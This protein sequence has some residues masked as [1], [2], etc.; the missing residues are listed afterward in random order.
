VTKTERQARI[1]IHKHEAG[2]RLDAWL[3]GRFTYHALD[4]WVTLIQTERLLVNDLPSEADY[5]LCT[6]DVIAYHP[7]SLAEPEVSR[8]IRVLFED[9]F[10]LAINK[11][12]DLPC[13]PAGRYFKNTVLTILRETCP[14]AR[15]INRLD[16]ETSGV[17]L[18]AKNKRTA[19][20]LGKQFE[21]RQVTKEYQVVVEG[22]F[23]EQLTANGILTV[24]NHSPV[25]KKRLFQWEG[26]GETSHT[27]FR[28]MAYG[29][30][31]S[32]VHVT[33]GTGRMHQIRAT[34]SCLGFPVVGDKIYGLDETIFIRLVRGNMTDQDRT[35]LRLPHQA[36]HAWRLAVRHPVSLEDMTFEAPLPKD[37]KALLEEA[38][39]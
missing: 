20:K 21:R 22:E 38:G 29:S 39:M 28:R 27:E 17:M 26:E 32:L 6:G 4:E 16:R 30:G 23:P 33:L 11:P 12:A 36:L 19:G 35:R 5:V 25:I 2:A 8:D 9:E 13:H 37:V 7:V 1:A 34:L 14:E 3:A 31:L 18:I 10:I 15:L 24:D